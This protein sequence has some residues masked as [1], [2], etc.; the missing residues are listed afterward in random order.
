MEV[1]GPVW[2]VQTSC[3]SGTWFCKN[4]CW[5]LSCHGRRIGQDPPDRPRRNRPPMSVVQD[6]PAC[7]EIG[8]ICLVWSYTQVDPLERFR[9][10]YCLATAV[11]STRIIRA[12]SNLVQ[13]PSHAHHCS[14][15]IRVC[16]N[17]RL[18]L[19]FL[20]HQRWPLDELSVCCHVVANESN[21][22]QTST[23]CRSSAVI[24]CVF[25]FLSNGALVAEIWPFQPYGYRGV[26]KQSLLVV[27]SRLT[28]VDRAC[29]LCVNY[30]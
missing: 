9:V 21:V 29:K 24:K 17:R 11:E 13:W 22:P 28:C 30:V 25:L 27:Y 18:I 7:A 26:P 5:D 14:R 4:L 10:L 3:F 19:S 23:I 12:G 1:L 15:R 2:Q 8:C 6:A 20:G 16:W